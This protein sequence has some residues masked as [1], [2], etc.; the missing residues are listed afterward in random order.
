[1]AVIEITT[2]P[3]YFDR[4]SGYTVME[5]DLIACMR[6]SQTT[7]ITTT[8]TDD[9]IHA[10]Q[11]ADAAFPYQSFTTA[12]VIEGRSPANFKR[13][14]KVETRTGDTHPCCASLLPEAEV[15]Q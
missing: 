3:C 14:R 12:R 1:M 7:R 5:M 13:I 4:K 6:A 9:V 2:T 15:T 11:E 8:K 10:M